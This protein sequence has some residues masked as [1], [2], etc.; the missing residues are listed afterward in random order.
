MT[1][2]SPFGT[3]PYQNTGL[4]TGQLPA[5]GNNSVQQ[6]SAAGG[7]SKVAL[8]PGGVDLQQRIDSLGHNT[9]DV[10]Q[11]FLGTFAQQLLGDSA[12]GA[13]VSFDSVA[14]EAS[15]TLAAGVSRSTSANGV[16][17]AAAFSLSDSSHFVGKGTITLED[18]SKFDFEL[19]VQYE[20]TASAGVSAESERDRLIEQNPAM[21]LPAIEFPDIDWPGSLSDLFKMMDKPVSGT[22]RDDATG[23]Q[24]GSLSM[25]LLKLVNSAQQPLTYGPPDTKSA[26]QAYASELASGV[27]IRKEADQPA[28]PANSAA[29]IPLTI[30]T[31]PP[32]GDEA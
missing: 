31:T 9:L 7:S 1:A 2:I 25:R 12:K 24:L 6:T 29:D 14:L 19:E 27:P 30:S 26:A 23:D 13:S 22:V 4:S 17:D 5:R 21:P 3:R 28:P 32:V 18:G 11:Q 10:A 20:A 8:S 15:S 16:T